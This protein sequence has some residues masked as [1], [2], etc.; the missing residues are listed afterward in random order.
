MPESRASEMRNDALLRWEWEG[1]TPDSASEVVGAETAENV[2]DRFRIED[3]AV[4]P[5]PTSSSP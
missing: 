2:D 3:V 1:G 5:P 4:P